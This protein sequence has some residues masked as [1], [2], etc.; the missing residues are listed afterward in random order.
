MVVAVSEYILLFWFDTAPYHWY[1]WGGLFG[2]FVGMGL[3]CNELLDDEMK[4]MCV[5][6]GGMIPWV[7]YPLAL[8][9]TL[10]APISLCAFSAWSRLFPLSASPC[11]WHQAGNW[12]SVTVHFIFIWFEVFIVVVGG[13]THCSMMPCIDF[14]SIGTYISSAMI[15]SN[16]YEFLSRVYILYSL[17]HDLVLFTVNMFQCCGLLYCVL[18]T[19][20]DGSRADARSL[21]RIV[22]FC[23]SSLILGFM[24]IFDLT[25]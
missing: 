25:R 3:D 7:G 22:D 8:C 20:E 24:I 4:F 2:G 21:N 1:L 14:L 5:D 15:W 16:I 18:V 11:V 10:I 19:G 13:T 17:S 9:S 6:G 23:V 12:V